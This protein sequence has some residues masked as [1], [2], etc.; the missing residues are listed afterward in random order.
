MPGIE[1][2]GMWSRKSWRALPASIP[3]LPSFVRLEIRVSFFSTIPPFESFITSSICLKSIFSLI[4]SLGLDF[5]LSFPLLLAFVG[6]IMWFSLPQCCSPLHALD[7]CQSLTVPS[8]GF[9]NDV[10]LSSG[11]WHWKIRFWKGAK[12]LFSHRL[13][14]L[15]SRKMPSWKT[16][17]F[18]FLPFPFFFPLKHHLILIFKNYKTK[19]KIILTDWNLDT[20]MINDFLFC[21]FEW[22][23]DA[24][25]ANAWLMPSI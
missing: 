17:S 20:S 25:E 4:F 2:M 11:T 18:D 13:P 5:A 15:E 3:F 16:T 22:C 8:V 21:W 23:E 9:F 19:A 10:E 7:R 24:L 1:L 6:A 12:T 14:L